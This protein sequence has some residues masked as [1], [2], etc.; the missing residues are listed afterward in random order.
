MAAL[1][2]ASIGDHGALNTHL[3]EDL[4][5]IWIDRDLSWLDFNQ[6]VLAEALDERTPLLERVKFL[7]I[8]SS[9]LDEFF[10][11]RVSVLRRGVGDQHRALL[12]QLR[13]KLLPMLA[14]QADC[15]RQSVIPGLAK[16]GILLRHWDELT[17][18]QREEAS[19]HF[20]SSVSAALTPLV[21]DPEHPFPF[22]SNLSTSLTFR[23]QDPECAEV[24]H[25]RVKVPGVLKNW[26]A[27]N[28]DLE[29]DQ[30]LLVPLYE[31]IRGN[32]QKLYGGM[33]I[34]G[35]SLL[36]ITRDAEVELDDDSSAGV[37]ELVEEQIRQRRYEPIVRLEF[38]PGADPE[39]KS[40]L[41]DGFQLSASDVYDMAGE[42]DYTTL[43]E[44]A[45]LPVPDLRDPC[46]IPLPRPALRSSPQFRP[47]TC[48][49]IILTTASTE[50][51]NTSLARQPMTRKPSP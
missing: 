11:K 48:W 9:N 31:V 3:P 42:V 29:K 45:S 20:D 37:R 38:G 4:S 41:R 5:E 12:E 47:R 35:V 25:A 33:T 21:I 34:S 24:M 27:L 43:F 16:H 46:W 22:L 50:A 13:Q 32:I 10:M 23:L 2:I 51:S 1:A 8:F 40:S 39:I 18:R 49:S 14:Q 6:R 30:K 36:R 17:G 44:I 7:A 26:I 28:S 15:Y 19:D